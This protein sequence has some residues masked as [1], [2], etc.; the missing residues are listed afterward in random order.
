MT[1]LAL[2]AFCFFLVLARG[3]TQQAV[4]IGQVTDQEGKAIEFVNIGIKEHPERGT[5]SDEHGRFRIDLPYQSSVTI[6]LSYIGYRPISR[7][8]DLLP[9]KAV[10]V[11]IRIN[12][13]ATDLPTITVKAD[14][15]RKHL[16]TITLDPIDIERIPLPSGNFENIL[17]TIGLGVSTAGGELSSQY[18]V[19]GGNFD[20]NLVYVNDFE[21]YRPQLI[22]SGQQ[23]GLSF[24]N[25]DLVRQ[26][27]FSSGGFQPRYGDKMASVLDVTYKRPDSLRG[28]ASL[29]LMLVTFHLEGISKNR[30][31]SWLLGARQRSNAY[32]LNT[33][34]TEGEYVPN[35][36]DVQSLLHYRISPRWEMEALVNFNRT[37]Y[38]FRPASRISSIGTIDNVKELEVFFEGQEV[39]AFENA[40]GGI[41][42]TYAGPQNRLRLKWLA[43]AY[44]SVETETFDVLGDYFL[45][46]VDSD[47]GSREFNERLFALGYGT[48]HNFGRNYLTATVAN[49]GHK[50]Y[51]YSGTH[52]L[53]WGAR[54]QHEWIDDR[55]NEWERNDS[56][57]YTLPY[58]TDEVLLWQVLKTSTLLQSNRIEAYFQD[59]WVLVDD[60]MQNLNLTAGVRANYWDLNGEILLSPRA[61]L[62]WKPAWERNVIL[63]A[64]IG[65]YQQPPFYRELRNFQGVVNPEVRAQKSMHLVL[66]SDYVFTAWDREF[67]LLSEVYYKQLWDLVPY[68][69]TDV[70]IRYY[71]ENLARG[72]AAGIDFRLHGQFVRDAESYITVSLMQT[73]EDI[74]G[75]FYLDTAG[76]AHE[77]GF[78]PRPTDQTVN[79][80]I[81]F[82]DY[83]P[84]NE[85]FKVHLNMLFGTGLPFGPPR[86]ARFRNAARMPP[87]RRVDIGFSALLF[88]RTNGL[89]RFG[90]LNHLRSAWVSLEVFNLLG[91]QN[92]ISHI[93]IKDNVNTLYAFENYLTNRRLNLRMIVKF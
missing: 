56:A 36:T 20:E 34:D 44:R 81:M 26:V 12:R 72:Y 38:S 3:Y 66:G 88:D 14:T 25:S 29:S 59:T 6:Q 83:L 30:R 21:V 70:K 87:Y 45:Y 27:E 50:G 2:L 69:I 82:Q 58:T 33:L 53:E 77:I 92:T 32:L 48:Y 15:D 11:D 84:S 19:R 68:D 41:S 78:L 49:V 65:L 40:M 52:L 39:N 75:D 67:R 64:A 51:H 24:I 46:Q 35:A 86:S 93:W 1:R 28:S 16:G 18:S 17:K 55:L 22:R 7:K 10:L 79:V 5:T 85:N 9:D 80:G 31:F 37:R 61:Q 23:E 54:Y 91:I 71:G 13:S 60:S 73:K 42:A 8:V 63:R 57:L 90:S 89:S 62:S 43:S 4:I 47:L 74:E 76:V